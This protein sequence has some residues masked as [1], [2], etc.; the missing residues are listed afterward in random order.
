MV[1]SG[2]T[3]NNGV[4]VAPWV[5]WVADADPVT[6]RGG[7]GGVDNDADAEV[8]DADTLRWFST[9]GVGLRMNCKLIFSDLVD[10]CFGLT[11]SD[12]TF[13]CGGG[14]LCW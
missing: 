9:P 12:T 6:D 2:C 8:A 11:G 14:M 7:D 4:I 3:V 1:E 13:S 10:T 5:S